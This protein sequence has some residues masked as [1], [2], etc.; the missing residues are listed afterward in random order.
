MLIWKILIWKILIWKIL[1]WKILIWKILED[2]D[3]WKILIFKIFKIFWIFVKLFYWYLTFFIRPY[4]ISFD[5]VLIFDPKMHQKWYQTRYI[6][7]FSNYLFLELLF[8]S[9]LFFL[10]SLDEKDESDSEKRSLAAACN[11]LKVFNSTF[12]KLPFFRSF[13]F[14]FFL[15]LFVSNIFF[16]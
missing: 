12:V 9:I 16:R 14:F 6:Y 15:F 10:F 11:C 8:Y 1:I 4:M 3:F 7:V 13:S 5:L 2:F